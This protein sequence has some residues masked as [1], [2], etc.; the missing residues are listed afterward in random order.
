[1]CVFVV[2]VVCLFVWAF[3]CFFVEEVCV[4]VCFSLLKST[5]IFTECESVEKKAFVARKVSCSLCRKMP[6][7]FS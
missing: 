7:K 1:M 3:S 6:F 2:V 5:S 4:C